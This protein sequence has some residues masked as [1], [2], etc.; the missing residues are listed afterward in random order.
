MSKTE[1]WQRGPVD[2]VPALLQPVAHIVLQIG[3]KDS[4]LIAALREERSKPG[5]IIV[6]FTADRGQL[7]KINLRVM[8]PEPDGGSVYV[9]RI[10]DFVEIK[11]DR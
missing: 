10:K 1:W 11:K 8:V 5:C 6:S 9:L 3:E 4:P 2:G 7:D